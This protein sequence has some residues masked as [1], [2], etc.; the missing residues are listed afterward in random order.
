MSATTLPAPSLEVKTNSEM[1]T[2]RACPRRHHHQ[3]VQL[4]R[5]RREHEALSFGILWH[6]GQEAWWGADPNPEARLEA[7]L[8][9]M[10]A[11]TAANPF[12][13][14]VCEELMI[15]YTALY[16]E[17]TMVTVCVEQRFE[18]PLVN[19]ETGATSRT[20][21]IGGKFDG[22]AN[23]NGRLL[24]VEHKSTASDIEEG[25][26]YWKKVQALD[27]QV[28]LYLK[29]AKESGYDVEACL[30]DVVRK[31]G[32]RPLK[33][34]PVESR[35]YTGKGLLY[36]NQREAD[37]SPEEFRLRVRDDIAER[38]QRYFSRGEV[39]RLEEDEKD[40]AYD[41]WQQARM[42]R[43][44]A[45]AGFAPKNPDACSSF[46]GCPYLPVC[47]GE[48]SIDDDTLYRTADTAHE[49]LQEEA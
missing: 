46:G 20:Y 24:V 35:K 48:A 31:P 36:A 13:L 27:T 25:S 22:I 14:V 30:Y 33:A 18:V 49:E 16:G 29:G 17:Q 11:H 42:M 15:A 3:Y 8:V 37:E 43:E 39:V 40:F 34:T 21:R 7:A 38:P 23:D 10:R 41:V 9:A 44:A 45:L 2:W 5:P 19:P 47:S 6:V 28:S 32:I 26:L 4:R 12:H 1:R